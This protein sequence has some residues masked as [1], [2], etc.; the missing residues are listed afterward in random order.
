MYKSGIR[1]I[2]FASQI[3]VPLTTLGVYTV[4]E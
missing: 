1:G 2:L 3:L 4:K